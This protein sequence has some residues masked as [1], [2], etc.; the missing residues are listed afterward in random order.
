MA[1]FPTTEVYAALRDA[2]VQTGVPLTLLMGVAFAESGFDPT[3]TGE[4]TSSGERAQGL[5]QLMAATRSR[6]GVTDGYSAQQ[7][8]LG[9]AKFLATLAKALEW[10]VPAMLSAYVW[11]PTRYAQAR[12]AGKVPP[13]EVLRYVKRVQNAQ[14][15][16]RSQAQR[17]RGQLMRALDVAIQ[18]LAMLN[19]NYAPAVSLLGVWSR[20]FPKHAD[21]TDAAAAM[22]P[23]LKTLWKAYAL[24]YERAPWT[25]ETTPLPSDVEP[26]FWAS[27]ARSVDAAT[28]TITRAA[29]QAAVGV[30]AGLFFV[31]VFL[32]AVAR[33][34]GGRGR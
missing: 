32:V 2:A 4:P 30:G 14:H 19:P 31:A 22:N 7:S 28:K 34:G 6:Y 15:Y 26:D 8:A 27:A 1:R 21:D 24:A 9:G 18:N 10:N 25:D 20:Y 33:H 11:G 13:Q 17:P 12:A 29:G 5:M 3:K 23:S 16:Y